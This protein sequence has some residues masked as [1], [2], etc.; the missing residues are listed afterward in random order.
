MLGSSAGEEPEEG[1]QN[2]IYTEVVRV[3][4][5]SALQK[6][7]KQITCKTC[8]RR[9][10]PRA[11]PG[12]GWGGGARDDGRPGNGGETQLWTKNNS[13]ICD[14]RQGNVTVGG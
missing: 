4:I 5:V 9:E 13:S 10:K 14:I 1:K 2:F 11:K 3:R 8:F 6:L 12:L 7:P